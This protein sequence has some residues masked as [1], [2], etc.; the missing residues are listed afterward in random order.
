VETKNGANR[1]LAHPGGGEIQR[2]GREA[3]EGAS[4]KLKRDEA[5]SY[6]FA[7]AMEAGEAG[8]VPAPTC[9]S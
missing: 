5:K 6:V 2:E 1:T 8:S 4:A 7:P 9:H 3:K